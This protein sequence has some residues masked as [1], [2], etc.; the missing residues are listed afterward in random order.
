MSKLD[1]AVAL[2]AAVRARFFSRTRPRGIARL[3]F[4]RSV[5]A[6]GALAGEH[7][8]AVG[9]GR[10]VVRGRV[11]KDLAIRLYVIQK[12]PRKLIRSADFIPGDYDGIPTDVI[13][14]PAAFL[15]PAKKRRVPRATS[16]ACTDRRQEKQRPIVAGTSAAHRNVTAGTIACFCTSTHP[17]DPP[18]RTYVLSNNHVFADVNQGQAG[19]ELYQPGRAD[20]GTAEDRFA[21]LAR[22]GTIRLDGV[23]NRVDAAIGAMLPDVKF[24]PEICSIGALAGH[25]RAA[26]GMRVRKHGRTTGYTE[27]VVTDIYYDVIV[28][29][30]HADPSVTATFANQVRIER[31]APYPAIGLGGDSGSLVVHG[32]KAKAVGLY[33]AGPESGAYGIANPIEEVLQDLQIAL[34]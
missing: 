23:D 16:S 34:V 29:M 17:D 5:A 8:H 11:S 32:D 26:E 30:D 27:G 25:E 7:V 22:F 24:R 9:V 20:G 21:L 2:K 10:K 15:Q 12:L 3:G 19:D 1:D 33:F 13:E 28:G 14:T 6:A 31:T 18:D 4:S